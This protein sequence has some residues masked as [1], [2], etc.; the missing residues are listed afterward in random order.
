MIRRFNYTDRLRILREDVRIELRQHG[1]SFSFSAKLDLGE[2]DLPEDALVF[3]EA[4]RQTSW[5]RFEFGTAGAVTAPQECA[6]TEF[7]SPDDIRFR[8][9]VTQASDTHV[10][11]AEADRIPLHRPEE[12]QDRRVPLLPVKPH[13]LGDEI[14]RVDFSDDR[15]RLL[16]NKDAG[17]WRA[18]AKSPAFASL[19]YPA[20]FREVLTRIVMV[21]EFDDSTDS[22]DWR[23]LWL[24]L[25]ELLPGV[26]ECPKTN[27]D[28]DSSDW[29]DIAVQAFATK[30]KNLGKFSEY[31]KK[32]EE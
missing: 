27:D 10:L 12:S 5:M 22:T 21:N 17:D 31:W 6:L 3:V 1:N 8:V 29:I 4:Y 15:P 23:S 30:L 7:D 28:D 13:L 32:E 16:V 2:Y 11:L 19:V 20:V 9:K 14:Y 25:A 18:I 24:K 26:G